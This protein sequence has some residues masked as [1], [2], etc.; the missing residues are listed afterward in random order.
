MPHD[1]EPLLV[2]VAVEAKSKADHEKLI[3]ALAGLAAEDRALVVQLDEMSGQIILKGTSEDHLKRTIDN[4]GQ[5]L[6]MAVNVGALQVAFLERPTKRAEV[7]YVH[8]KIY[9]PKGEFAALKLIIGPNELGKGY[10]FDCKVSVNALPREYMPGIEK[11]LES[12]LACGVVAGSPVIDVRV[13]LIDGKYHDVDS[14]VRAFEIAARAAFREGLQR[15]ESVLLEP[16]MKVEVA[17]PSPFANLIADDLK[18]RRG[19]GHF[20]TVEGDIVAIDATVPLI[21]MFGYA[22]SLRAMSQGLATHTMRFDHYGAAP[23]PWD[24]PPFRP[25]VGMRA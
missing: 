19:T 5:I 23:R 11:G 17:T 25:A 16:I 2:E 13:E 4:L 10:Q 14:S 1:V 12:V 7:D 15:A 6:G 8:K 20:R 24:N 22:N 3:A 21:T 18:A 9:G